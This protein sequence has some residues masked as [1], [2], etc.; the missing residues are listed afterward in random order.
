MMKTLKKIISRYTSIPISKIDLQTNL[1]T[2]LGMSSLE[3]LSC[4]CDIEEKFKVRLLEEDLKKVS[5]VKDLIVLLEN[6][7][8]KTK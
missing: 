5:T 1:I 8:C 7:E 6:N 3:L 4:V 2:D